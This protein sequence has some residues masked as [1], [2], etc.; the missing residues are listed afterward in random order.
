MLMK[1]LIAKKDCKK[2]LNHLNQQELANIYAK[3][4]KY[5]IVVSHVFMKYLNKSIHF[6]DTLCDYQLSS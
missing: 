2:H 3:D 5:M 1:K 6:F 4:H